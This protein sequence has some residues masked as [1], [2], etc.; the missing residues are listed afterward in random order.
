[1]I[2]LRHA[3]RA[4]LPVLERIA[5]AAIDELLSQA[6]DPE[7]LVASRTIMGVDTRLVDD[8]TYLVAEID[9]EIAGCGGWSRRA[10]LYGGDHSPG[11]DAALLN[12]AQDPARVRAMYTHPAFARR[13]V[14]RAILAE[15]ER[16]ARAEAFQETELAATMSGAPLYE[17]CGYRPI[18]HFTDAS[19]GHPVPLIRMRK[20]L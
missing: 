17:A 9:G 19:G 15:A 11:R 3:T 12:P 14:G 5:N 13:G 1:M 10:T 16:Q 7:E 2:R 20:S 8:G 6:L 18:E 4:D